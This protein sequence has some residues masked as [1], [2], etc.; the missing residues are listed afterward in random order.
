MSILELLAALGSGGLLLKLAELLYGTLSDSVRRRREAK[1]IIDRHLDPILKAADAVA[2]KIRSLAQE[3]FS[4]LRPGREDE[5]GREIR[6]LNVLH[7]LAVFWGRI[8]ILEYES[9]YS[10]LRLDPRGVRLREFLQSLQSKSVRLVDR[11]QQKAVGESVIQPQGN[12]WSSIGFAEF[13]RRYREDEFFRGW[14]VPV[15]RL[16]DRNRDRQRILVYVAVVFALIDTMDSRHLVA[17]ARPGYANKLERQARRKLRHGVFGTYL[18]FV[19][20]PEQ[21]FEPSGSGR[22]NKNAR[23]AHAR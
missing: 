17:R 9:L 16:L 2:G 14:M 5:D 3:D 20:R 11:A 18:R 10:R 6:I 23:R 8:E 1:E 4:S 12:S 15:R 7:L 13:V 19:K 21:Y 22:G